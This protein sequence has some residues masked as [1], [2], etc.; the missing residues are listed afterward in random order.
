METPIYPRVPLD[1]VFL[2]IDFVIFHLK[3]DLVSFTY[4]KEY[5]MDN[6]TI[7]EAW[8]QKKGIGPEKIPGWIIS[9]SRT[10]AVSI[11]GQ[12]VD[13]KA[14]F[15]TWDGTPKTQSLSHTIFLN[16]SD[17]QARQYEELAGGRTFYLVIP[18]DESEA[19]V[20]LT[21]TQLKEMQEKESIAD[22]REQDFA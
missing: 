7:V 22:E 12:Q 6:N 2:F 9:T 19:V 17:E 18:D 10:R 16:C 21:P 15:S 11:L 13:A 3:I 14:S 5:T 4:R 8:L 20:A 1:F